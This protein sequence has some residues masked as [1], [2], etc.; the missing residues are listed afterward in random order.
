MGKMTGQPVYQLIGGKAHEEL[1]VPRVISIKS[2]EEM[3]K[4]AK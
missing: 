3:A 1:Q 2:P 4:D